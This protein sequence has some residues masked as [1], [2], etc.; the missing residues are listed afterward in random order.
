MYVTRPQLEARFGQDVLVQAAWRDGLDADTV[1]AAA[2][3]GA[4]QVIDGYL[5][6]R[7]R[8]PLVPLV[9]ALVTDIATDI[10]WYKLWTGAIP[11][12]V[13][14]R[15]RDAIRMLADIQAGRMTLP[16]VDGLAPVQAASTDNQVM[17]IGND[18][19]QFD[20]QTLRGW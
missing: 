2:I 12:D 14:I 16:G 5:G 10:T 6:T 11:D 13:A 7:F 19:R 17:L 8:L 3:D 18:A 1:I 20:S 9:P 4:G 15:Y